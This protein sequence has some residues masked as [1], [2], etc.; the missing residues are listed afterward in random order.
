MKDKSQLPFLLRLMDDKSPSV[1]A[2][3][4]RELAALGPQLEA[5]IR[6]QGLVPTREQWALV[7]Q[8]VPARGEEEVAAETLD[9]VALDSLMSDD[10]SSGESFSG[11]GEFGFS[12]FDDDAALRRAWLH[13]LKI[14]GENQKLEAALGLLARWQL[15]PDGNPP[16]GTLLDELAAD[17]RASLRPNEPEELSRW[18]FSSEGRDL[19]GAPPEGLYNPLH[20]NLIYVIKARR[21][22][23]ISLASVFI[24]VG[25]RLGLDISGCNFPGHFL[26]RA[27]IHTRDR[28]TD[29]SR[30]DN[31]PTRDRR[32]KSR[33][34]NEADVREVIFDC[35]GG[36]ALSA[37]EAA[38]LSKAVPHEMSIRAPAVVIVAR[39]LRNLVIAFEQTGDINKAR[40]ML[41]LLS[42]LEQ[43]PGL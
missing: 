15:G 36:R 2:K 13:W 27:R 11:A 7:S 22:I 20:S 26:A 1:R 23:P 41:S 25:H 18:L 21:G 43:A 6:R 4:A 28:Q 34:A 19:R 38:A 37:Q 24:L 16:L 17:F 40:F 30:A 8:I 29:D 5:E 12:G 10:P 3:V 39:T 14:R 42:E 9:S 33:H 35:Y 31:P 32:A